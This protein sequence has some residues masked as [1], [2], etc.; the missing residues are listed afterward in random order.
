MPAM[1]E[2]QQPTTDDP[3]F[4][5][6]VLRAFIKGDRLVSLPARARKKQ[7]V[8]RF[9]VTRVLSDDE[10]VEEPELNRRLATWHPDFA[11]LR[12]YLVEAGLVSRSGMS[13][14]RGIPPRV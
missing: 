12:R 2:M 10:A 9:L 13:Y 14:R 11:A 7:V 1:P 8:L 4:E 3:A 6:R 5:A